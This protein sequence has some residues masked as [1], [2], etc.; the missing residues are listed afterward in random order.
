MS[1]MYCESEE[2]VGG[3][4][5]CVCVA[6]RF[7]DKAGPVDGWMRMDGHG[8]ERAIAGIKGQCVVDDL[9]RTLKDGKKRKEKA[10]LCA[11]KHH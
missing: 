5:V 8:H 2:W 11:A 1:F 4:R 7:F 10:Y 6:Y 9:R 3:E